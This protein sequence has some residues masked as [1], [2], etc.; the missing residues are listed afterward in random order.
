[1]VRKAI[2][3]SLAVIF[4]SGMGGWAGAQVA[5]SAKQDVLP[6][7]AGGGLSVFNPDLGS[8]EML[9]YS[10]WG[11]YSPAFLTHKAHGLAIEGQY[12][13]IFFHRSSTQ[14]NVREASFLGGVNY[15][16]HHFQNFYPMASAKVGF[17]AIDFLFGNNYSYTHDS[18]TIYSFSGGGQ[19]RVWESVWVRAD[20]EYQTWPGLFSRNLHPNGFTFGVAYD[21]RLPQRRF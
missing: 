7:E 12:K 10:I 2:V 11:D 20:Y 16:W 9:G 8:G 18:R 6:F 21:F 15:S 5:P 3:V 1:M 13:D 19:Y 14:P 17:G 4:F